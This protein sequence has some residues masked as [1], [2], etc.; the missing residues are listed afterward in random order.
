MSPLFHSQ[1]AVAA[2]NF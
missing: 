2:K 1:V